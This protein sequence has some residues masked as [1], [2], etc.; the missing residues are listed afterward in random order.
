MLTV[1]RR[2]ES[3]F[4]LNQTTPQRKLVGQPIWLPILFLGEHHG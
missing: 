2:F 4:P 1:A 3:M